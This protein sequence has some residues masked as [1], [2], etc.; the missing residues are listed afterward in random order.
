[1]MAA[2][3]AVLR[4]EMKVGDSAETTAAHSELW[5]VAT[6]V[7]EMVV[8]MAENWVVWMVVPKV[9]CWVDEMA[10]C[11]VGAMAA[12]SVETKAAG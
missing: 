7:A 3:K 11:L 4:A 2:A 5:M 8:S 6:L 10:G 12:M 1:M 9:V